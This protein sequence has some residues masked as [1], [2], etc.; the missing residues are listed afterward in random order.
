MAPD[1]NEAVRLAKL[2]P[3]NPDPMRELGERFLDARDYERAAEAF[4]F[5][6]RL[7]PGH[8]RTFQRL[9]YTLRLLE[10]WDEAAAASLRAIALAPDLAEAY[11]NL[12]IVLFAQ[13]ELEKSVL[14]FEEAVRL[15]PRSYARWNNLGSALILCNR[16][17]E[18]EAAFRKA[19]ALNPRHP[20]SHHHLGMVLL[21]QGHYAMGWREYEWRWQCRA[22]RAVA[23]PQSLKLWQ[24]SPAPR[25]ILLHAE[26]GL[27]DALQFCRYAPLVAA[28]GHQVVL[29]VPVELVALVEYSLGSDTIR[30]VP[31]ASD[32]PGLTG[33]PPVD[34][35]CPL[36]SLPLVLGTTLE[37]IPA[38]PYLR[39]DPAKTRLW[40]DRLGTADAVRIGLVWAGNPRRT[41]SLVIRETDAR[42]S[43]RLAVLAPLLDVPGARFVS[44][45]KGEGADEL[46][47][48]AYPMILD[49]DPDLRSFA[50]TAALVAALDLVICVDTSVAHLAAGMGKPI[51][52]LSRFDGCW[53]WLKDRSDSPWY[54]S[55]R[56]FRQGADRDWAPV[57]AQ[58]RQALLDLTAR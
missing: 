40:A 11:D 21:R 44:L 49:A 57:V 47:R 19:V 38:Q 56:I 34:A 10:R 52:L 22:L 37:T 29:E 48:S 28:R 41:A 16:D 32:H 2:D 35:H 27:G 3:S 33:L 26:Q 55:M 17:E 20:D 5:A 18:A 46:R 51:W 8:A 58:I 7:D 30:V 43:T 4:R 45:Q 14:M 39:A 54:P 24:G 31:Q 9:G 13:R 23:R 53:R 36:L 6:T 50:D 15:A 25:T 12:A 42:R 1:M